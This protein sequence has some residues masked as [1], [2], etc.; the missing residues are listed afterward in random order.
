MIEAMACGTP[1]IAF[2][3]GSVEEIVD[4]G[5]SGFVVEDIDAAAAAVGRI[6]AVDRR[7]CRR[8][9]ERRFT[10]ERMAADYVRVYEEAIAAHR[11]SD[12]VA[13]TR[14]S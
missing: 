3:G 10:D 14:H 1:V 13:L 9:F 4:D 5:I 6:D 2:R 7:G 8:T 12:G 11:S